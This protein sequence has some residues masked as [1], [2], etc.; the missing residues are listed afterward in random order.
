[1]SES[2]SQPRWPNR[3]E[4]SRNRCRAT[5][6]RGGRVVQCTEDRRQPH[7]H[8]WRGAPFSPGFQ[9]PVSGPPTLP[10]GRLNLT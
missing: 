3:S 4:E 10:P 7:E 8:Q 9:V 1:M 5:E 2:R 6:R